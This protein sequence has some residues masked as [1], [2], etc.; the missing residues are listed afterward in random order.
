MKKKKFFQ[1]SMFD[2]ILNT[3]TEFISFT[4]SRNITKLMFKICYL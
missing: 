4:P 3:F 1:T 2:A